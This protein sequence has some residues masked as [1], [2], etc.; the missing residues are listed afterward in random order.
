MTPFIELNQ[1]LIPVSLIK[2]VDVENLEAGSAT[3][4]LMN[5]S[6]EIAQGRDMFDL[7]M[8]LKPSALEGRR[9]KWIKQAWVIHNLI[10]H[11]GMQLLA[12]LGFKRAAIRFH[13][14]TI[15]RPSGIKEKNLSE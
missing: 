8:L 6:H 15:P 2:M 7:I 5:G 9:F 1:K 4:H 10:G 14:A 13:D 11:P 3:V 12:W